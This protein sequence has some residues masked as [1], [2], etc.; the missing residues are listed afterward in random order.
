MVDTAIIAEAM[1]TGEILSVVY[2]GGTQSGTKRL[3]FPLHF[4]DTDK[5]VARCIS[6]WRVK[7]FALEKMQ[8]VAHDDTTPA[9][10]VLR[11]TPGARQRVE[12]PSVTFAE[13]FAKGWAFLVP[14]A[15]RPALDIL[16]GVRVNKEATEQLRAGRLKELGFASLDDLN[17]RTM[18]ADERRGILDQIARY[19]VS[20]KVWTEGNPPAYA[21]H[22]GDTLHSRDGDMTM[23]VASILPLNM[24][25]AELFHQLRPIMAFH[26]THL[27]FA[28]LLRFGVPHKSSGFPT[29]IP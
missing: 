23:Q 29:E 22:E 9:Y 18:D 8:I 28:N 3:I 27:Q 21:F 19:K 20:D 12:P 14:E 2:H 6:T 11:D 5:L 17:A 1:K 15:F 26:C 24:L 4:R 13:G 10:E 25:R 16:P 7:N